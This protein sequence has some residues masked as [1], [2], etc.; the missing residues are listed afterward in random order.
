[1]SKTT[2]FGIALV[3]LVAL[4]MALSPVAM[5]A[6]V[7]G[8]DSAD[9]HEEI[10]PDQVYTQSPDEVTIAEE[11]ETTSEDTVEVFVRMDA[12]SSQF[13]AET[14]TETDLSA[15]SETALKQE[16]DLTQQP[17][18]AY[19]EQTSGVDVVNSFW[20]T[21]AVLLEVDGDAV[22]DLAEVDGVTELHPN[23]EIDQVDPEE[24]TDSE[25][26]GE[27]EY[28]YGVEQINAPQ[29]WDGFDASG[30]GATVAVV[31][32]GVNAE[33]ETFA[34]Y[35]T[36]NWA[37]FDFDGSE[38]DSEPYDINGHGTHV[39]GTVLGGDESGT[40][41]GVAPDAELLAINVF[42]DPDG[43]T[44]LAAIVA[45]MEEAVEEGA[46][47]ANFSLGGAGYAPIYI[48]V[49]KNAKDAGTFIVTSSGNSGPGSTGTPAN[50][51]NASAIGASDESGGITDFSTGTEIDTAAE[52]GYVAPESWP[53]EYVTPDVAAPGDAVQSAYVPGDDTYSALSGTSMAAPHVSGA[54]ALLMAEF[55][56]EPSETK[57]VLEE[58]ATKPDEISEDVIADAAS[59]SDEQVDNLFDDD[60]RDVRY[61]YG[62]IDVYA[63]GLYADDVNSSIEGTVTDSDEE[64]VEGATVDLEGV[65]TVETQ[66]DGQFAFDVLPG[67]YDLSATAFGGV[68]DATVDVGEDETET[69][70]IELEDIVDVAPLQDQPNELP[71]NS[72]FEI[73][74]DVANLENL[75]VDL[76]DEADVS[77]DDLNVTL[78]DGEVTL[79]ETIDLE[80]PLTGEA[81]LNVEVTAEEG[82]V[83]ELAH[84]F[85]GPGEDIDVVTGPTHVLDEDA[86]AAP[87]TI[88]EWEPPEEVFFNEPSPVFVEI[89]NSGDFTEDVTLFHSIDAEGVPYLLDTQAT[90]EAGETKEVMLGPYNW[91]VIGGPGTVLEHFVLVNDPAEPDDVS[92]IATTELTGS[93]PIMGTVTDEDTGEPVTGATVTAEHPSGATF[94][95]TT[96]I[97]GDYVITGPEDLPDAEYEL[98][99]EVEG[100]YDA[101]TDS[102]EVSDDGEPVEANV[103]LS[104][105]A[106]YSVSLDAD[107]PTAFGIPGPVEAD[108]LGD[109][110]ETGIPGTMYT[111]DTDAGEWESVGADYEVDALDAFV[112]VPD[113]ESADAVLEIAET[114]G[115]TSP[116]SQS[117]AN[118]WNFVSPTE[119][120]ATSDALSLAGADLVDDRTTIPFA[121]PTSNMA[122]ESASEHGVS[123]FTA[124]FQGISAADDNPEQLGALD[125]SGMSLAE[126]NDEL[127][128]ATD[129]VEG[130]VVGEFSGQ[131]IDDAAVALEGTTF[132][133]HTG[134]AGEFGFN[135]VVDSDDL[136]VTVEA[137]G[138][139]DETAAVDDGVVEL[140]EEEFLGVTEFEATESA[141][142]GE[143]IE[144]TYEV[145]NFGTQTVDQQVEVEVGQNVEFARSDD[146]TYVL[147]TRAI[148]LEP[149]ESETVTI[150]AEVGDFQPAG[151]QEIAV[152]TNA[153]YAPDD[154]ATQPFSLVGV[155]ATDQAL[156][157]DADENPTVIVDDVSA[158]DGSWVVVTYE[159]TV[160]DEEIIAG[161][162]Q[163]DDDVAS[164]GVPVE[165][166]DAAAF[167]GEHTAHVIS[168]LSDKSADDPIGDPVSEDTAENIQSQD[169]FDVFDATLEFEDQNFANETSEVVVSDAAVFDGV[170][171]ETPF[172][173]DLHPTDDDDM[174]IPDEALGQSDN[175]TG[176]NENVTID[177]DEELETSDDHVAM[178]HLGESDEPLSTP[179]LTQAMDDEL[180]PVVD[181]ATVEI[182]TAIDITDLEVVDNATE[183]DGTYELEYV[184]TST[185][186][187][188]DTEFIS[189]DLGDESA[190]VSDA[191]AMVS[192]ATVEDVIEL[193][194]GVAVIALEEP[195]EAET[196]DAF[197]V[198]LQ[199]VVNADEVGEYDLTLGLHDADD[200]G[201]PTEPFA[202]AVDSYE[203]ILDPDAQVIGSLS[204]EAVDEDADTV[205]V[206]YGIESLVDDEPPVAGYELE[207]HYDS[208][209]VEFADA[210]AAD[211]EVEPVVND[212]EDGE[213]R[214]VATDTQNPT[215]PFEPAVYLEFNTS[216]VGETGL[217][218]AADGSDING[219]G[220]EAY[221][222]VF[223]DGSVTVGEPEADFEITDVDPSED[224]TVEPEADLTVNTTVENVGELSD[225]QDVEF[226]LDGEVAE[227]S[228]LELDQGDE[229]TV[230]FD[231]TAPEEEG[232]LEWNVQTDDDESA[233]WN[234]TVE[235]AEA[236]F[237]ITEVDPGENLTVEPGDDLEINATVENTG[238][239][240]DTQDV[241]FVLGNDSVAAEE[242]E[243]DGGDAE[244]VHFEL[245][246]PDDT[247]EYEWNVSTDDDT[248]TTWT[249]TVE[250]GDLDS[251]GAFASGSTLNTVAIGGGAN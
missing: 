61:G 124:Y 83:V 229:E 179:A 90:V 11:L 52:W 25:A 136:E 186:G 237:E 114:D 85:S 104:S 243:L 148:E 212:E 216:E 165:I 46:D 219:P 112:F 138:F 118:G 128:V 40:Q 175:L 70:D 7:S 135:H 115:V 131:V 173:I 44:T 48:D 35:D 43:G 251:I 47:V 55:D 79:G 63:A 34:D 242:T 91:W 32:T 230:T 121:A 120:D 180:V 18:E 213:V 167:P 60:V 30:E 247:G 123:P 241:E 81:V 153:A 161:V 78:G 68:G 88:T 204:D 127:G 20:L 203:L 215:T 166:E 156:G 8:V 1:M 177:L 92:D 157:M 101:A 191:E 42:P 211:F 16:A 233:T 74:V 29:F 56:L 134:P 108:T 77:E 22:E 160:A 59:V 209:V 75:T 183:E 201:E 222:P 41:I 193:D 154:I 105:D 208:D 182:G 159:E 27:K 155:S 152:V 54:A 150:S 98:S 57:Y 23:Y 188:E 122:P 26:F 170:D 151:V 227:A 240:T 39:A 72:S 174:I 200:E 198:T 235:P 244:T 171:D 17:L 143:E 45:G 163:L 214:L 100:G 21:N 15:D 224:L 96:D 178:L 102:V 223:E 76:S 65:G 113:G 249:L 86:E 238:D 99:V 4:C 36:D 62:I 245:E 28:T 94:T 37:E 69:A 158:A 210:H 172:T 67:E 225:T 33:H 19:A 221:D 93:G 13:F 64:P 119:Y 202:A 53:D 10:S 228:E 51:Y 111:Y 107:E 50:V 197:E 164:E 189:I 84:T 195:L 103:E 236:N 146:N 190:N 58:T 66:S 187:E 82:D 218:I 109:V 169:S 12:D 149:D 5:A 129:R 250:E 147:D 71:T 184:Y 24:G 126:A 239:Q 176:E 220:G 132:A 226:V 141:A 49:V 89:E 117:V 194:D 97:D 110:V 181:Q 133:A 125:D 232:T 14:I 80:E 3:V 106:T 217:E 168:E 2:R 145:T 144:V 231:L 234:L 6:S 185:A 9:A 192:G 205:T 87:V 199:D 38:I 95:A 162:T 73:V 206:E 116:S 139:E 248:S 196:G 137:D 31:D 142:V 246:A 207:V 130:E 140:Q